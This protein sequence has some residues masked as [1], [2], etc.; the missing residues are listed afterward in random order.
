[1]LVPL[2]DA[3]REVNDLA[4]LYGVV[5]TVGAHR[6]R[7]AIT[8][9]RLWAFVAVALASGRGCDHQSGGPRL[10]VVA[11]LLL[12]LISVPGDG[13]RATRL[14]SSGLWG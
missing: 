10:L 8:P 12:F 6:A 11:V 9:L 3:F 13:T 5:A 2:T 14:G 7:A 4:T 1:M